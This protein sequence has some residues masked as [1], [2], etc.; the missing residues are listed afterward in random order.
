MTLSQDSTA[1]VEFRFR[2]A[3]TGTTASRVPTERE[4]TERDF[5]MHLDWLRGILGT[6][7][8]SYTVREG[9]EGHSGRHW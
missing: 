2:R 6:E 7:S 5:Q 1:A 4:M 9:S 8:W 3:M